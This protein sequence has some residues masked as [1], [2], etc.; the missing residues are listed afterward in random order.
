MQ[1]G[2]FLHRQGQ[3]LRACVVLARNVG[4]AFYGMAN[5]RSLVGCAAQVQCEILG[6]QAT[7]RQTGLLPAFAKVLAELEDFTSAFCTR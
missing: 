2:R 1:A 5:G 4:R 3:G 6:H 7:A